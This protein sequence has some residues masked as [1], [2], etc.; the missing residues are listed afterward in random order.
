MFARRWPTASS[1]Q[2]QHGVAA[3]FRSDLWLSD[4]VAVDP[5]GYR[6]RNRRALPEF[7]TIDRYEREASARFNGALRRMFQTMPDGNSRRDN[8]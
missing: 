4:N 8:W 6:K 2:R 3:G 5:G 1:G 7:V